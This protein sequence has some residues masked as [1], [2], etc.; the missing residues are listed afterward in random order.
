MR[1]PGY[2][3]EG[4]AG[5]GGMGIVYRA[6]Q[7]SI[8][9]TVALK[10]LPPRAARDRRFVDRF[11]REAKAAARLNHPNVVSAIDAGK[12][13]PLVYFVMEYVDGETA[14]ALVEREGPL[15]VPR[16]VEILLGVARALEHAAAHGLV[17][18]DVKPDN[19]MLARDGRVLLCD[20]GLARLAPAAGAAGGGRTGRRTGIAEGT[21]YY[22]AP[23]QARG[24]ADIDIRADLY[25]LGATAYHL[26]A[27][28][29]PFEGEDAHE[30]MWK[31]VHEPF[32]S[33]A[34]ARPDLPPE[35]VALLERMVAKRPED[36]PQSPAEVRQ[37]L[38]DLGEALRTGRGGGGQRAAHR[39][40]AP[41]RRWRAA[42]LLAAGVAALAAGGALLLR[43]GSEAEEVAAATAAA[44]TGP[45]GPVG[46]VAGTAPGG[47]GAARTDAPP[48]TV[49][50]AEAG[51]TLPV[52]ADA[53][54][55]AEA[56]VA[57]RLLAEELAGAG[58]GAEQRLAR[59]RAIATRYAATAAARE[60]EQ[61]AG[62]LAL[63]LQQHRDRVRLQAE[64]WLRRAR[65]DGQFGAAAEQLQL[66][67]AREAGGPGEPVVREVLAALEQ[68]CRERWRELE[69]ELVALAEAGQHQAARERAEAFR[70]RATPAVRA[71]LEARLEQLLAA[72]QAEAAARALAAVAGEVRRA[73]A[74]APLE[75]ALERVRAGLAEASLAPHRT[76]LERMERELALGLGA[77]QRLLAAVGEL[78]AGRSGGPQQLPLL[79]GEVLR[80]R[81]EAFDPQARL[82][83]F[84][85]EGLAE[86]VAVRLEDLEP[87]LLLRL[88]A[89]RAVRDDQPAGEAGRSGGEAAPGSAEGGA[90][91]GGVSGGAAARELG[92]GVCLLRLQAPRAAS[93][94]LR[95]VARA[96][97]QLSEPLLEALAGAER[98]FAEA[99]AAAW[100]RRAA[101]L[102]GT[103]RAAAA[104]AALE[105]L[106]ERLAATA[107]V[108]EHRAALRQLYVAARAA[109]LRAEGPQALLAGQVQPRG[110]DVVSVYYRFERPEELGDW[111]PLVAEAIEAYR[112]SAVRQVAGQVEFRGRVRWRPEVE[113]EVAVELLLRTE[114]S[115]RNV[116]VVLYERGAWTGWLGAF[117]LQ[118]D[119]DRVLRTSPRAPLRPRWA[120]RLPAHVV[121]RLGG[122]PAD[123][124][125]LFAS[126]GP[127]LPVGSTAAAVVV[128]GRALSLVL[129]GEPISPAIPLPR[130]EMRG[131]IAL[132]PGKE[133]LRVLELRITGTLDEG[134]L[135]QERRRLAGVEWD[136]AFA[137]AGRN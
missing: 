2:R 69:Q 43:S 90:A 129:N 72:Q 71:L 15:P 47:A 1:I 13:G 130:E 41:G 70:A 55:E 124:E 126:R 101:A 3:L 95:A 85:E 121:A 109:V 7:L 115:T 34:R 68:E 24:L 96:G 40:A 118:T 122:R 105:P 117:M 61:Q 111:Q 135:E 75:P 42:G 83:Q 65:A 10:V 80:G 66:L 112:D 84:V 11:L 110:R 48:G 133:R 33:F 52:A 51:G 103:G 120:F 128:R 46:E 58:V 8:G 37:A 87:D 26:L 134:W 77:E 113:G 60:A 125:F 9:R 119:E 45:A 31:Q 16:A 32:P 114:R 62:A 63:E 5:R 74:G 14:A 19:I 28:A 99:E 18:R 57:W 137:G 44:A 49:P 22:M 89:G 30:V 108:R 17:H 132:V 92:A 116:N 64:G 59:L 50:A 56:A 127:S 76:E 82:V 4:V 131:G 136:A 38:E 106:R 100:H 81:C 123:T 53:V 39:A 67:L 36:R 97:T 23:E 86:P 107:W 20:L 79:V 25:G 27:G 94:A 21:P 78:V 98:R 12:A 104:V 93:A 102:E 73:L 29:P 91:G 54:R 6:E 88:A 35:L